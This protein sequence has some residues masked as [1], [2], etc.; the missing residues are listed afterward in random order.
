MFIIVKIAVVLC[1]LSKHRDI[2]CIWDTPN[3]C[4]HLI[5]QLSVNEAEFKRIIIDILTCIAVEI[6]S[7]GLLACMD[8]S[9]QAGKL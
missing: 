5:F 1:M 7:L 9:L 3:T 2:W 6:N 4:F 8:L